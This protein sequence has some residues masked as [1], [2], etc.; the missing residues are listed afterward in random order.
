MFHYE[1][2][3]GWKGPFS[4]KQMRAWYEKR[5]FPL[6][7]GDIKNMKVRYANRPF[8]EVQHLL[9]LSRELF[10]ARYTAICNPRFKKMLLKF[11]LCV[12]FPTD[13]TKH[14]KNLFFPFAGS[15]RT[16]FSSPSLSLCVLI[17]PI[18]NYFL[19]E[20]VRYDGVQRRWNDVVGLILAS[21]DLD[22]KKITK[23]PSFTNTTY[24]IPDEP[25]AFVPPSAPPSAP[26][27]TYKPPTSRTRP[28]IITALKPPT[29]RRSFTSNLLNQS[30]LIRVRRSI[31]AHLPNNNNNNNNRNEDR[32]LREK[33]SAK[34][35]RH[36]VRHRDV[37]FEELWWPVHQRTTLK[38]TGEWIQ[39][40]WVH[41][42]RILFSERGC[43]S[44]TIFSHTQFNLKQ[45]NNNK[46]HN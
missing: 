38:A 18:W 41:Q 35:L 17:L 16:G 9:S 11:S 7:R 13:C 20:Q 19:W 14:N 43:S 37:E 34:K 5:Y 39:L 6:F 10:N 45:L 15:R 4:R 28:P 30:P 3:R 31:L 26:R 24:K 2:C 23:R 29:I 21:E 12:S 42:A 33:W 25:F 46:K 1:T 44:N 40:H 27:P 22:Q 8:R 32:K 36:N